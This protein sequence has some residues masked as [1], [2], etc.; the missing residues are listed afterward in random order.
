MTA[1]LLFFGISFIGL[2]ILFLHKVWELHK[3]F[4]VVSK[5]VFEKADSLI[6]DKLAK[7]KHRF[8]VT[9]KATYKYLLFHARK[10][11]QELVLKFAHYLHS[12]TSLLLEKLKK[13]RVVGKGR[14]AVSF[15]LSRIS[16]E[17]KA[18]AS[19]AHPEAAREV[20]DVEGLSGK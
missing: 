15:Y 18:A 2:V 14:G 8:V 3:G 16:E 17:K 11:I 4:T 9:V 1:P 6:E 20:K 19:M 12:K 7:Q 13:G 10:K 5:N